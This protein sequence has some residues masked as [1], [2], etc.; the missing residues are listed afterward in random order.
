MKSEKEKMTLG[1]ILIAEGLITQEQL[2]EVL[3]LQKQQ[4]HYKPIGELC[5][6]RRYLSREELRRVIR[7]YKKRIM[8]GELLVNLSIITP[9]QLSDALAKQKKSGKRLGEV[10]MEEGIISDED[11]AKALSLQLDIPLVKPDPAVVDKRLLTKVTEAFLRKNLCVPIVVHEGVVTVT[12]ADPLREE[13]I[14]D[15]SLA[16]G[17]KIDVGIASQADI[18]NALEQL[19]APLQIKEAT[20]R[21]VEERFTPDLVIGGVAPSEKEDYI[22]NIVNH[23]IANGIKEKASDIHIEC[24]EDRLRVRYRID[25]ILQHKTDL[26]IS[27]GMPI[28]SRIKVLAGL[29][30]TERRKHQDGR[31]AAAVMGKDVDLRVSTYAAVYGEAVTIRILQK[32]TTLIELENLGFSP[33]NYRRYEDLLNHPSGVILVTGPTGSGKTTTLY[34]SLAYLNQ[35]DR[36]IITVEDPVEVTIDGVI[37]GMLNPKLHL[38]YMDFIKSMMRQD[39]DVIMIGEI[40][41]KEV[42]QATVQAG[43]TGHKVFSSFHTED[44]VGALLRL[45]DMGIDPFLI[46]STVVAVLAQR[47]VRVLCPSCKVEEPFNEKLFHFFQA[48]DFDPGR[49]KFY[50]GMGCMECNFTG[51]KGRMGIHELL[52]LNDPI[53]QAVMNKKDSIEIRALAKEKAGLVTLKED[54]LYKALKGMTSPWEVFRVAHYIER[55]YAPLPV[56]EVMSRCEGRELIH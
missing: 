17:C 32:R 24:L 40:R 11:L 14:K 13:V 56:S 7:R 28:V 49:Q 54:G 55:D 34:A 52:I 19:F 27:L 47:L 43:L 38:N 29:D 22:V 8:L 50:H 18:L 1:E 51:F 42:A 44:A 10:L 33:Y 37:Q 53:R 26:P 2:R 9:K 31:I 12:M 36:K 30:I 48:K 20:R 35:L 3:I 23:L 6:E 41:D 45:T 25:G 39:P 46:T 16:Y 4:P 15:L 21:Y 5:V